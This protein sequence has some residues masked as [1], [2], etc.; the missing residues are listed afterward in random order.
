MCVCVLSEVRIKIP[1]ERLDKMKRKKKPSLGNIKSSLIA[2]LHLFIYLYFLQDGDFCS[3]S[4]RTATFSI[5]L[6]YIVPCAQ[7]QSK[8]SRV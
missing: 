1:S 3:K 4:F 5:S 8:Y 2:L 7:T 6:S